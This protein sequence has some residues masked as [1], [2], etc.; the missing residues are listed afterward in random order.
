MFATLHIE[1]SCAWRAYHAA[2]Y[3]GTIRIHHRGNPAVA[4][5]TRP[6]LLTR[7]LDVEQNHSQWCL[8]L[9][10]H[11]QQL[12]I[13]LHPA[14]SCRLSQ[15]VCSVEI[16]ANGITSAVLPA[17][18]SRLTASPDV[19]NV[20]AALRSGHLHQHLVRCDGLLKPRHRQHGD[21]AQAAVCKLLCKSRSVLSEDALAKRPT[22]EVSGGA[23][24]C[25]LGSGL[26]LEQAA[27]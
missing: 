9:R 7:S 2:L 4:L 15:H 10:N 12:L 19:R 13:R 3:C 22:C 21:M 17:A 8:M 1:C 18:T 16:S 23:C 11:L 27:L 24:Q 6:T 25:R 20:C 5:V 14:I 26:H